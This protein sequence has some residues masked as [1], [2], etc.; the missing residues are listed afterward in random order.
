MPSLK[1]IKRRIGSVG[2]TQKIT[3]AMKLVS[4]AKFARASQAIQAA[5]P[6]GQAFD[7]MVSKLA[8]AADGKFDL[9][10]LEQREEKKILVVVLATDRGLCGGLNTNL[11]KFV[12]NAFRE[13]LDEKIDVDT[14]LWGRRA[15][16]F[17]RTRLTRAPLKSRE[18][19]LAKPDYALA[20]SLTDECLEAFRQQGYDRVYLA[21]MEFKSA[22][23]QTPRL[24]Q[25]LPIPWKPEESV[26]EEVS[27][28]KFVVEPDLESLLKSMLMRQLASKVH[29]ALLN[30]AASEHGARMTA[31]DSAT[32]NAK[33]VKRK[34]TLQYNR[35]RQAAITKE[36]IEI[37]SGAEAL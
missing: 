24:Q 31:M 15:I 29:R 8:S 28:S 36:L 5:R 4:A 7:Q 22:L 21:Y 10:L 20:E 18:K 2:N 11:F 19:V 12:Q 34:L 17:G 26:S 16:L 9:E 27:L 32:N 25:L 35:A 37:I 14:M 33:E 6:Y 1:D 3:R 13:K 23:T 30:A